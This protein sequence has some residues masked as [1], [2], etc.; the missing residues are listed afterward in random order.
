MAYYIFYNK[1]KVDTVQSKKDVFKTIT[2]KSIGKNKHTK[3]QDSRK[4]IALIAHDV[5]DRIFD[6]TCTRERLSRVVCS[7]KCYFIDTNFYYKLT[8]YVISFNA[9]FNYRQWTLLVITQIFVKH[10]TLLGNE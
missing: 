8:K 10:K 3:E 2:G 6:K 4:Q 7:S 9:I 5:I 1:K